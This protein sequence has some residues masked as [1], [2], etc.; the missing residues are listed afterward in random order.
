MNHRRGSES[1]ITPTAPT[2][3]CALHA[4]TYQTVSNL[5]SGN[6]DYEKYCLL[7]FNVV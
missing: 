6:G 4:E 5:S 1:C 2:G 7:S 3:G